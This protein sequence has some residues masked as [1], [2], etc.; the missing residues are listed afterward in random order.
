V[1]ILHEGYTGFGTYGVV[2]PAYR[3]HSY[4]ATDDFLAK[5][6]SGDSK[7]GI[8]LEDHT[9]TVGLF[10]E[11]G[12]FSIDTDN[13]G[14]GE[15]TVNTSGVGIVN[16][17][18][19]TGGDITV[20]NASS[21]SSIILDSDVAGANKV[22]E[23]DFQTGGVTIAD[24]EGHIKDAVNDYGELR[25]STK[26]SGGL[27]EWMYLDEDGEWGLGIEPQGKAHIYED[28]TGTGIETGLTLEQDGTGDSLLHFV[29]TGAGTDWTMGT[30]NSST[31]DPFSISSGNDLSTPYITLNNNKIGVFE[32]DPQARLDIHDTQAGDLMDAI[33]IS[34]ESSAAGSSIGMEY[35]VQSS[36]IPKAGEYF[37]NVDG[38]SNGRGDYYLCL[39]QVN[40]VNPVSIGDAILTGHYSDGRISIANNLGVGTTTIPHN[41]IGE[42]MFALEGADTS[43]SDGPHIQ[44]TTDADDYPL[45]QML[46]VTHDDISMSFDAYL[47]T[48]TWKSSDIG[49]NFHIHKLNDRLKFRYDSGVAQGGTVGWNEGFQLDASGNFQIGDGN[50]S[51]TLDVVGTAEINGDTTIDG[52]LV[53][54]AADVSITATNDITFDNQNANGGINNVLGTDTSA[55]SFNVKNNSLANL[56]TVYGDGDLAVDTDT[57]YVDAPIDSVGI[58][59]TPADGYSLDVQGASTNARFLAGSKNVTIERGNFGTNT[60]TNS[61]DLFFNRNDVGFNQ[62]EFV[63]TNKNNSGTFWRTFKLFYTNDADNTGLGLSIARGGKVAVGANLAQNKFQVNTDAVSG[64]GTVTISGGSVTGSGTAFESELKVGDY[65]IVANGQVRITV[66]TDNT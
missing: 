22:G 49:S 39:D 46:N 9:S 52:D 55:T 62:E 43:A 47:E 32:P 12:L 65:I 27:Q 66:I 53:V 6:Q 1:T 11:A 41:G 36:D 10:N 18:S 5:L 23:V 58:N 26:G 63:L 13:S 38:D 57:L 54:T 4:H 19:I 48:A 25:F 16:D 60:N 34:N 45:F 7:A 40:D 14:V 31:N 28:T 3:T 42:A 50:F 35:A 30:D 24:V 59:R 64:T 37:K 33:K 61:A 21:A 15:M 29:M 56:L 44:I 20:Y 8:L 51:A 17:L 2:T